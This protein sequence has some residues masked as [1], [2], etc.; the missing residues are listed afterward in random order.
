VV[1]F[2]PWSVDRAI[3]HA[4]DSELETLR[5]HAVLAVQE[6]TAFLMIRKAFGDDLPRSHRLADAFAKWLALL[7]SVGAR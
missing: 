3:V 7:R 6:P 5:A 4:P 1:A 2:P